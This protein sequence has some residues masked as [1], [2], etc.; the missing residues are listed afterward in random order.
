MIIKNGNR[1]YDISRIYSVR[2]YAEEFNISHN[3][4]YYQ[5]TKTLTGRT[6]NPLD[7]IIISGMD[8]IYITDEEFEQVKNKK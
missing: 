2:R 4:V 7:L 1:E 5:V 6:K 3:I 8:F